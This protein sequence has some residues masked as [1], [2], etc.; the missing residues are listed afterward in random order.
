MALHKTTASI[1]VLF[2]LFNAVAAHA[3]DDTLEA[4]RAALRVKNYAQAIQ[5]LTPLANSGKAD[6]EYLLGCMYRNGL[7][8]DIDN[9]Q[10]SQWMRRAADHGDVDAMYSLAA[11]ITLESTDTD[12]ASRKK[13]IEQWLQRAAKAGHPLATKALSNGLVPLHFRADKQ[14]QDA[15]LR[16]QAILSAADEDDV[17]LL[18]AFADAELSK[19]TDE[20]G[21]NVFAH[22]AKSGASRTIALLLQRGVRVDQADSYGMTPLMLAAA[23]GHQA[24]VTLLIQ[25]KVPLNSQD[26]VGNTALMY[27]IARKQSAVAAQLLTAGADAHLTNTQSWT[28]LDWVVHANADEVA[29]ALRAQGLNAARKTALNSSGPAWPLRHAST[30]DLYRDWPDSLIAITRPSTDLLNATLKAKAETGFTPDGDNALLVA[31]KAGN[32]AAIEHL[33]GSNNSNYSNAKMR[34]TPL[35][36]AVRHHQLN[37]A[38]LLLSKGFDPN[39]HGIQ[40][41]APLVDAVRLRNEDTVKA[42]LK[43]LAKTEVQD[44]TGRTPLMLA[45]M[46]SQ[47]SVVAA[48]LASGANIDATDKDNRTALW[49]AALAGSEACVRQLLNGKANVDKRDNSGV[50]ALMAASGSGHAGTVELLVGAGASVQPAA[51]GMTSPLIIAAA[52]GNEAIVQRLI[53]GGAPIDAQNRFGDT[54]LITAA[55]A[56]HAAVVRV[57]LGAGASAELRNADRASA[58]DVATALGLKDVQSLL[59]KRS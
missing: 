55:R 43:A 32:V 20:F 26:R 4:V 27:A 28:A 37:I 14:L 18:S 39:A 38:Q 59:S 10:A 21:R 41:A 2:G 56:G 34:E 22:A 6:A 44:T 1:A 17:E 19:A 33:L 53:A 3:T 49:H 54:A 31:V 11:L 47:A 48:L 9:T 51:N 36:Y 24:I 30:A 58:L 7:G 29:A 12:P 13:E 57:L 8:V 50:S 40:E 45:A 46:Q 42:L 16:T 5:Q 23:A 52:S 35:S 25:N 15:A